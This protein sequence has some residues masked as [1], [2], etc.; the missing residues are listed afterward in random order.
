[1]AIQFARCEYV[2]RSTGGNACRKAAYNERS[3][4]Q[5]ERTGETFSF[6]HKGEAAHHEVLLPEGANARFEDS[7]TLWNEAEWCERRKDSQVAKEFVLA[8]P[9][10]AQVTLEDRIELTRRFASSNFVEKGV[11]VQIDIHE[12]DAEE[13]NWHAHLL[14]TTRRF[15]EDGETL[16]P[17]KANDLDPVV[18]GAS[19]TVLE[20]DLWGEIWRDVQNTY[21]E[22]KGYDI[23][24]D[25]IAILSQEHLG[26]V[27]MRHHMNQAIARSQELAEANEKLAH[28][29]DAILEALTRHTALFTSSDVDRFLNKHV[30]LGDHETL[31]DGVMNHLSV[32]PLYHPDSGEQTPFYTTMNVRLEEE[33]LLRFAD[34]IASRS[35]SPLGEDSAE[36]GLFGKALNEEQR[37]AYDSCVKSDQNLCI[38]QGRAGVGKSYVLDSVRAAHEDAGY[39]VLGL[40]PTHKVKTALKD[41]GLEGAKT[42]HEFLFAL[43]HDRDSLNARTLVVVDEAGMMGSTLSVELF[44]AVKKGGAKLVLVG[45]DRQLSSVDRQG[46]FGIL[47]ERHGSVELREVRRQ[48]VDWQKAVSENL[49]QGNIKSAVDLLQHHGAI[50]WQETKEESLATL[51]KDWSQHQNTGTHQILA[52]RNIDVD[53]LN[54]GA[55]E[56]LRSQ[57]KL[58]DIEITCA[59]QRGKMTF[60]VGDRIQLT[61]TDKA[62]D[63]ENGR[64]GT[65]TTIDP[66]TKKLT[67]TMDNKDTREVDPSTYTGLR[68]GYAATVYKAQGATLDHVY[69]LHGNT[70]NQSTNY[71]T[72]TRQTES[73]SLYVSKDETATQKDLIWQMGRAEGKGSSLLFDTERDIERRQE[74]KPFLAHLKHGVEDLVTSVKDTF[75]SNPAFYQ[76]SPADKAKHEV[77]LQS[78]KESERSPTL[79]A[80]YKERAHP[81]FNPNPKATTGAYTEAMILKQTFETVRQRFGEDQAVT[82]WKDRSGAFKNRYESAQTQEKQRLQDLERQRK[83]QERLERERERERELRRQEEMR[84][85]QERVRQIQRERDGPSL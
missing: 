20:A 11:A 64:F 36:K 12:P 81:A 59:T 21:F 26:P 48:T 38:I 5:C 16:S 67:L 57:G 19:H 73:L 33:K 74:D 66:D 14:V 75:H 70:T 29:P 63:L 61:K 40:A 44:N 13:K 27:R 65:I 76:F 1:M 52:Q 45:D 31:K 50:T 72:L 9:D 39:R 3:S 46:A 42:C 55:R 24:V 30:P 41:S 17:K 56:I 49:S 58:R 47:A 51:L 68:H 32:L 85:E 22:E 69:V 10:D 84:R 4:I 43:R 77:T 71:V 54:E 2:S 28:H 78:H 8:L 62:Q 7:S 15:A 37:S 6:E 35:R 80:I 60:A 23:R 18:R 83:E 34:T 53:A 82:Y 25:P 79:Q